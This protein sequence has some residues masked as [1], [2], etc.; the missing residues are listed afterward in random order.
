MKILFAA[1]M[2]FN[3][4]SALPTAAEA[5]KIMEQTATYFKAADFSMLNLENIFGKAEEH[6]PIVKAGPNLISDERFAAF[7]D[8]LNPTVVGLANNH[9]RD[10]GDSA[11]RYTIEFMKNKGYQVIGAGKNI[12]EAYAPAILEKDGLKAAVIA[13]NENEFGI[14]DVDAAGTAGYNLTRVTKAIFAAKAQGALPV[15][16]FHGGNE[17]NPFPSPG[18]V[19]LYRHFIDLG[20]RAVIAMH[21]HCPQGYEFYEGCPIVYSMGNFFFPSKNERPT[22][23]VGYMTELELTEGDAKLKLIPYTFDF[24]HHTP[25]EGA[26]KEKFMAYIEELNA[27]IGDPLKLREYFDS[28]CMITGLKYAGYLSFGLESEPPQRARLKNSFS[29]EAHNELIGNTVKIFFEDRVEAAKSK[30]AEI[31]RLQNTEF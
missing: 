24:D 7:I 26:Q 17:Y 15:I 9:S 5:E 27:P 30:V 13:V 31:E 18:K 23:K 19:D 29:C 16:Y 11:L 4:F 6:T 10:F 2:S 25:M 3:Y 12:E 28:W 14:A 21:T 22:W 20:A 8:K 1:D